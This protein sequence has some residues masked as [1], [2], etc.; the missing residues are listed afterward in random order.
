MPHLD[1]RYAGFDEFFTFAHK[2]IACVEWFGMGLRVQYYRLVPALFRLL[3]QRFQNR[4][5]D[6]PYAVLPG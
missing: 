4:A 2:T 3:H 1:V 5:A 6:M